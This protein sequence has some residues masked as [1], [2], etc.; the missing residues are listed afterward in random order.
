MINAPITSRRQ[1]GSEQIEVLR[2]SIIRA[3][4]SADFQ[5][6]GSSPFDS[7]VASGAREDTAA[8]SNREWHR[9]ESVG[10]WTRR[11]WSCCATR[12]AGQGAGRV[13]RGCHRRCRAG[14]HFRRENEGVDRSTG[15]T[16]A[17]DADRKRPM[18]D[19]HWMTATAAG[20]GES[21]LL[22]LVVNQGNH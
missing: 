21:D 8:V 9:F 11:W 13:P 20:V 12:R 18:S 2:I 4:G 7:E 1:R 3:T 6:A 15:R 19:L 16:L 22:R 10:S 5:N 17:A 14:D